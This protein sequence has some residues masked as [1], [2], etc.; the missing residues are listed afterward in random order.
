MN[1][2]K[3]FVNQK[4]NTLTPSELERLGAKYGLRF[5]G[6]E[7]N[8]IVAIIRRQTVDVFSDAQRQRLLQQ[9][10]KSTHPGIANDMEALFK[11]LVKKLS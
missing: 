2:L 11:R 10:A 1:L 7:S 8:K 5:S 6:D 9:I 4:I 3:Q